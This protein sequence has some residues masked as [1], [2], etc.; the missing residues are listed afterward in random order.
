MDRKRKYK[1]K[2][3]SIGVKVDYTDEQLKARQKALN[4][5]PDPK[6]LSEPYITDNGRTLVYFKKGADVAKKGM[7]FEERR[8]S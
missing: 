4:Q 2:D 3:G 5:S 6:K 1:P 8:G 7:I